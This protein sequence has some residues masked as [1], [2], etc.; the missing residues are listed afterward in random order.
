MQDVECHVNK[1]SEKVMTL[2]IYPTLLGKLFWLL[3]NNFQNLRTLKTSY[4]WNW[5]LEAGMLR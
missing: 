1:M 4:V 2:S 5:L 3:A